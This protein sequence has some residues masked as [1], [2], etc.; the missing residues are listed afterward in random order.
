V[1]HTAH[2]LK[3]VTQVNADTG[4]K[5]TL[6]TEN[7]AG[8]R[9]F[10]ADTMSDESAVMGKIVTTDHRDLKGGRASIAKSGTWEY[11]DGRDKHIGSG[12]CWFVGGIPQLAATVWV[13]AKRSKFEMHEPAEY[14][15]RDM[16]GAGTPARVWD[17]FLNA[18]AKSKNWNN[19]AFPPRQKT[20]DPSRFGNGV[21]PPPDPSSNSGCPLETVG[22][23]CDD[24]PR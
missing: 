3:S 13:G 19:E 5:D 14:G 8:N 17:A 2:F 10:A 22:I 18:A 23:T 21:T 20:G 12:D 15:G 11:D 9:V 7:T 1:H 4:R 24:K 6:L 16:A